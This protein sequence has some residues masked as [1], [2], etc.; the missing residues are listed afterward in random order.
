MIKACI[1]QLSAHIC[2]YIHICTYVGSKSLAVFLDVDDPFDIYTKNN[3][4]LRQYAA[5][6]ENQI[7]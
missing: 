2:T 1:V 3:D 7:N 6:Q 5:L 4:L